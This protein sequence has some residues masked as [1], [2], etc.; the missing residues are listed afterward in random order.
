[1]AERAAQENGTAATAI[2]VRTQTFEQEPMPLLVTL[3]GRTV[4]H[5]NIE[6]VAETAGV[7]QTV[8]VQ[9]GQRVEEGELLCTLDQGTRAAAV[10]QSEAALAQARAGLEQAQLDFD[11]NA[12]L[13]ERGLAAA[14]TANA[15]Q[16]ALTGAEAQV[17]SAQAALDNA[18]AELE[19]TEIT[20]EVGGL[21]QTPIATRGSMLAQ[22][23]VCATI[24]QLDPI[25]F[26]GSVAEANITL[27]RTGLE[28]TLR[29]VTNQE[30]TGEVTYVAASADDATRSFPIEIEFENSDFDIRE[31]IT[32]TATVDMGSMPGHLLPQS[33]LTLNDE[34]VL[35]I[36]SVEDGVAA[37]HEVTIVSDTRDGVW[38]TGLPET[39]EIITIG[40][41]FVVDGQAVT[42][43]Q[44]SGTATEAA[45]E[46]APA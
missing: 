39:V 35:G 15:A 14:N 24:V 4:A 19:R 13:R 42:A 7:V 46:G 40:Q 38:V 23:G 20:A 25:V 11:T 5:A 21:V 28:A 22:G 9:K 26:S 43:G 10:A 32:A 36:R 27:A 34:G 3:R 16:V 12:S 17:L 44:A 33:V 45:E 1:V 18:N 2:S 29:T 6:A 8:H 37:F 30:A 41:E 31:G